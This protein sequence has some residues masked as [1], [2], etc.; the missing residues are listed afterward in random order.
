MALNLEKAIKDQSK[1]VQ[2]LLNETR[3]NLQTVLDGL[4]D[5]FR[6]E[7]IITNISPLPDKIDI[8]SVGPKIDELKR[9]LELCDI[10][11]ST[12]FSE[13]K[14]ILLT[15]HASHTNELQLKVDNYD[16]LGALQSLVL[17]QCSLSNLSKV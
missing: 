11:S 1:N 17:I 2:N 7:E 9:L 12:Q 10:K 4:Q 16:F 13:I 6:D 14:N 8:E 15:I 5:A 3:I